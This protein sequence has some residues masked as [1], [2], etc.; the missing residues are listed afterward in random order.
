MG[1]LPNDRIVAEYE[2][3]GAATAVESTYP[4]PGVKLTCAGGGGGSGDAWSADHRWIKDT[5]D[6]GRTDYGYT[7]ASL[8][9]WRKNTVGTGQDEF[10]DYDALYKVGKRHLGTQKIVTNTGGVPG[11]ESQ[12]YYWNR[13]WKCVESRQSATVLRNQYLYDARGRNDLV[14]RDRIVSGTPTRHY[15][16]CDAMGSKTAITDAAG[17]V[18]ER[19]RYSAFGKLTVLTGTF[20]AR[21]ATLYNWTTHFHGEERDPETGWHNYGYR[22]YIP[23]LGRWPSRDPIEEEGGNNHYAFVGNDAINNLDGLGLLKVSYMRQDLNQVTIDQAESTTFAGLG[24][25]GFAEFSGNVSCWCEGCEILCKVRARA[26]I[27]MNT[28]VYK[29]GTN[30]YDQ[31]VAHEKRHVMSW[32]YKVKTQV[33]FPLSKET[34]CRE[35]DSE[36][37]TDRAKDMRERYNSLLE[38]LSKKSDHKGDKGPQSAP[39]PYSPTNA[40]PWGG[41]LGVSDWERIM[42]QGGQPTENQNEK[43]VTMI[44][45]NCD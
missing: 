11:V 36:A 6:I 1:P 28:K 18:V 43:S 40:I 29:P 16:L 39:T 9:Q 25:A 15:A 37:C 32:F 35:K 5:A 23:A 22:Y 3:L 12:R 34:P 27:L 24:L 7:E 21:S 8:K 33:V 20:G 19:Y 41:D 30:L 42:A 17:A 44:F 38:Q 31:S 10:Y 14:L 45:G 13:S 4:Q 2:Y 26:Y